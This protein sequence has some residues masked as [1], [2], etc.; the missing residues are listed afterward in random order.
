M[1]KM[2]ITLADG[3]MLYDRDTFIA[4]YPA[5]AQ[6]Y[7]VNKPVHDLLTTQVTRIPDQ[8]RLM[9]DMVVW[10]N[11]GVDH[12]VP[13]DIAAVVQSYSAG[14]IVQQCSI[15][16][17]KDAQVSIVDRFDRCAPDASVII[18]AIDYHVGECAQLNMYTSA[19]SMH[20]SYEY[21]QHTIYARAHSTVRFNGSMT[22][23]A[24][25]TMTIDCNMEEPG[26]S[27]QVRIAAALSK[28]ESLKIFSHQRH[29]AP[30]TTT[31]VVVKSCVSGASRFDYYGSVMIGRHAAKTSAQQQAFCLLLGDRA[32]ASALPSLEVL[33]N[34]VTCAHGTALG[35]L[36]KQQVWYMQ[37]R[38]LS[39]DAAKKLLIEGFLADVL[40]PMHG[41][42]GHDIVQ[43]LVSSE[44]G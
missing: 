39:P 33:N 13:L 18:R 10:V 40:V 1:K 29:T 22:G 34:D 19:A 31:S 2:K 14:T 44:N 8:E 32:H 6:A 24:A 3:V 25:S 30:N 26:A 17:E 15:I 11:A 9:I 4:T 5:A 37:T 20:L 41:V 38:G 12:T 27:V 21:V 28:A 36:D 35:Q 16:V 42:D 43:Y 7:A 23:S